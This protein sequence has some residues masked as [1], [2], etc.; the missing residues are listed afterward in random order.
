MKPTPTKPTWP[1]PQLRETRSR[2]ERLSA[3]MALARTPD[4]KPPTA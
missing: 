1:E 2:E 3:L 4:R